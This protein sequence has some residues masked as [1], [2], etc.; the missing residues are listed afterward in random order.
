ML[1][2]CAV[3]LRALPALAWDGLSWGTIDDP[4]GPSARIVFLSPPPLGADG[5]STVPV[6]AVIVPSS[7]G[8]TYYRFGAGPGGWRRCNGVVAVPSGKQVL[9]AVAVSPS[10]IAGP[11]ARR[12]VRSDYRLRPTIGIAA[13]ISSSGPTRALFTGSTAVDGSAVTVAVDIR[14][15]H[16]G[17]AMRRLGGKD[18]YGTAA[19]LS[20]STF[21]RAPTVIIATGEKFPDALTASGLAGC[22]SAPVLL[23]HRATIP[24]RTVSEL[25]RLHTKRLIIIGGPNAVTNGVASK[26]RKL[27]FS[28]ERLYG[29]TRYETAIAVSQRIQKLTK[30]HDRVFVARGDKFPDA[31]L[32][33][34]LAYWTRSPIL[35]TTPG[36]L[37]PTVAKRLAQAKYQS[38]VIVG[39][40]GHRPVTSIQARVPAV[41]LWGGR[42]PYD[43]SVQVS[44]NEVLDG[45][46]VSWGY[47]GVA[48]G[49]IFPDALCGGAVAGSHHGVI[50]LTP[51]TSLYPEV[52]DT[53]TAHAGDVS[54]CEV[55]GGVSAVSAGVYNRIYAIL[56]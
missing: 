37:N 4:V 11:V 43:T 30:R 18:R 7:A 34:P 56:H 29:P 52:A 47:I 46:G 15:P 35:L 12:T 53:L 8:E 20:A 1:L 23:V 28:V 6:R 19:I 21:D 54:T 38:A 33:S 39:N 2:A 3:A 27:G 50:L 51:P 22:L 45:S 40:V 36:A 13:L 9:S 10:G 44:A 24:P 48:R 17:A 55:Y 16:G 14:S 5:Y 49:D 42:N 41:T 25:R 32:I 31:L 26:F